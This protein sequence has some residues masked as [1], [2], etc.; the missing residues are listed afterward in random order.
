[1]KIPITDQF[2]F[3]IYKYLEKGNSTVDFLLMRPTMRNYLPGYKNP[4]F[5]KYR[6]IKNR[7]KF[8]R[9]VYY[10]KTKGYIK[11]KN[12]ENKKTIILTKKGI[13]KALITSFKSGE[14]KL[15]KDGKWIMVIFD[16]PEKF[17]KSRNLLRSILHNL[18]YKIFQQSVW[19]TPY[20]VLE[21]TEKLIAMHS[22]DEYVKI[23]LIEKV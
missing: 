3:D 1:M 2:L 10:L 15:R 4:I 6:D 19:I 18:G 20:D 22:L 21:R 13:D 16:V 17:R 7:N 23:F 5:K 9:L 8:N 14:G 11:V 12:L